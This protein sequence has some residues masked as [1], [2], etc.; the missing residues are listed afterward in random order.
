MGV[1]FFRQILE[2]RAKL[3]FAAT[4]PMAAFDYLRFF[5]KSQNRT[6]LASDKTRP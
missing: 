6:F 3:A 4:A 5:Y 2:Q 1:V